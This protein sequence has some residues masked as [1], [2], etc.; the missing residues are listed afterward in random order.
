MTGP[1]GVA[2]AGARGGAPVVPVSPPGAR[3]LTHY[4]P[5]PPSPQCWRAALPGSRRRLSRLSRDRSQLQDL[6]SPRPKVSFLRGKVLQGGCAKVCK[7][8]RVRPWSL[9]VAAGGAFPRRGGGGGN[10][11]SPVS[12]PRL[13][14]QLLQPTPEAAR[15][16]RGGGSRRPRRLPAARPDAAS[17]QPR[18][19]VGGPSVRTSR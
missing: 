11:A 12:L 8:S 5:G 3:R 18:A 7:C 1:G 2:R 10:A 15:Q 4:D 13:P 14:L 6:R 19:A 9:E 16:R 17:P